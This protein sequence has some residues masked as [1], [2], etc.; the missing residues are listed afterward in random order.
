M[1]HTQ[2]PLSHKYPPTTPHLLSFSSEGRLRQT[3]LALGH[4]KRLSWIIGHIYAL[5]H[6]SRADTTTWQRR[7]ISR[8]IEDVHASWGD[9]FFL[10]P[11]DE[12]TRFYFIN[13]NGF[14]L[15]KVKWLYV[16]NTLSEFNASVFGFAETKLRVN[17]EI[18]HTLDTDLRKVF[19][20]HDILQA[21][22]NFRVKGHCLPGGV[23]NVV[24]GNPCGRITSRFTDPLGRWTC[25]SLTGR[26]GT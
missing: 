21:Q 3:C 13:I 20:H 22:S 1:G 15:D 16:I 18:R 17:T 5:L 6:H 26:Q 12:E 24:T 10:P 11:A 23:M 7:R 4:I 14:P 25:H 19:L 9:L 8:Q 2:H